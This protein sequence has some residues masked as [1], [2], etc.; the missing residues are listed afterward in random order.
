MVEFKTNCDIDLSILSEADDQ[1]N[2]VETEVLMYIKGLMLR[3]VAGKTK[4][5]LALLTD[6][7]ETQSDGTRRIEIKLLGKENQKEYE[8]GDL[9][10]IWTS[11]TENYKYDLR[12]D[13]T[14]ISEAIETGRDMSKSLVKV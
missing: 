14:K 10:L 4:P 12:P 13:E 11:D 2:Y 6:V 5:F 8:R 1:K 9:K 3:C 7:G